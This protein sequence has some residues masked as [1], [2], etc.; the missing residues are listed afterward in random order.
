MDAQSLNSLLPFRLSSYDVT[1]VPTVNRRALRQVAEVHTPFTTRSKELMELYN[2]LRCL[3][4]NPLAVPDE[5]PVD[6]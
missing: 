2:G 6:R 4:S 3:G 1:I 5:P